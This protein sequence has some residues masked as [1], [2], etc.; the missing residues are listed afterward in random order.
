ML[1]I[2]VTTQLTKYPVNLGVYPVNPDVLNSGCSN[3][4]GTVFD[5]ATL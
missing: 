2:V 5:F 4:S 3:Y 1:Y